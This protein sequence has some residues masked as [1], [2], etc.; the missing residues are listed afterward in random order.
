MT[1]RREFYFLLALLG[2]LFLLLN[3]SFINALLP[4]EKPYQ[5]YMDQFQ[6]KQFTMIPA[7]IAHEPAKTKPVQPTQEAQ[8]PTPQKEVAKKIATEK[9][10][11]KMT[12]TTLNVKQSSSDIAAQMQTE[13]ST[14][15]KTNDEPLLRLLYEAT[16]RN[17]IY[18]KMDQA[19]RVTGSVKIKFLVS[20][21][22][23]LTHIAMIKS[24]G[25]G[26]FDDAALNAIHAMS[27]VRN[28]D[29]YVKNPKYVTAIINFS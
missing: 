26:P 17:L 24:S 27:P 15:D 25:F 3:F 18:P 10:Q 7:Y 6:K 14:A 8:N 4:D 22:G 5:P 20:P 29:L 19:F 2:H 1:K 13:S 12:K 21:N 9:P 28:V 16:N 11:Q 23:Q